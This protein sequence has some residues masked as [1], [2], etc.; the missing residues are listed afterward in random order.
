MKNPSGLV[1]SIA[2]LAA[3]AAAAQQDRSV[4]EEAGLYAPSVWDLEL[5]L[6]ATEIPTE[7]F[8]D[9]A[10]G[11]G[12]GPP[13]LPLSGWAEYGKC[14]PEE[15]T[16]FHEVNFQYD[17]EPEYWAK[18]KR[19]ES[20]INLYQYTSAYAIPVVVS[21]LFDSDGFMMGFRM[22]TDDR[23]DVSVRE[24]GSTLAGYLRARYDGAEWV[25]QNLA[26]LE[27]ER[28]YQGIYIKRRCLQR[29][30]QAGLNLV[31]EWN[32]FRGAGQF[33]VNPAN[34][35][36]MEG[37]FEST[38]H[39][40]VTLIGGIPDREA[41]LASLVAPGPTEKDFLIQRALDCPGCDL[42]G[43]NL[44][45]ANLAGANL[46][47]ANLS[48]AN[49]HGAI[50]AGAI[51]TNA[52]LEKANLNRADL[53]RANLQGA[54]LSGAM[55]FEAHFNG[56]DLSGASLQGAFGGRVQMIGADVSNANLSL[57]DLREARLNDANFSGSNINEAWLDDAQLARSNLAGVSIVFTTMRYA[58]FILTD[59]S[60]AD[61]RASDLYGANL[62]G[63]NLT[64]A[65]FSNSRLTNANLSETQ[66]EGAKF[67]DA[68]LPPGFRPNGAVPEPA[69]QIRNREAPL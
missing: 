55:M 9:Y 1:L 26:R 41:R 31:M 17:D 42:S 18:A 29:D 45:R 37:Q 22:V 40:E 21:A 16:G 53:K 63:A 44:K 34:G 48:G 11:T 32:H 27:R 36:P 51:L 25:C 49:L 50:L 20:Q 60:Q 52:N 3:S 67:K 57:M 15:G 23:V 39:F 8:I 10:C 7:E 61:M 6:H 35:L 5:G 24:K 54:N 28:A 68:L 2:L 47:G 12:G 66:I 69:P 56:A 14:P 30:I 64:G 4:L 33:A 62:R 13:S 59:L 65:D 19:L 38:T 46:A 43:A 58:S